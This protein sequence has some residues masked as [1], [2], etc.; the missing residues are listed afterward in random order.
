MWKLKVIE[1]L[2]VKRQAL[3]SAVEVADMILRIDDVIASK[4]GGGGAPAAC[5]RAATA[6]AGEAP[7]YPFT[8]GGANASPV[9]QRT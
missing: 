9:A 1:P 4:K 8:A 5:H 2:R 3:E 7:V 6:R